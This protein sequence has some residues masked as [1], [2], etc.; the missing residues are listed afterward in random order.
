MKQALEEVAALLRYY[1]IIYGSK[2]HKEP[3][4]SMNKESMMYT[5]KECSSAVKNDIL[6]FETKCGMP[7]DPSDH[8]ISQMHTQTL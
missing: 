4:K 7:G 2:L 5:R 1:T 8:D 3:A 6:A